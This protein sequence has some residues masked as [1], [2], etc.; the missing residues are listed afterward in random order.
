MESVQVDIFGHTY[1]IKVANDPEYIRKLAAYVD[2][3]MKEVQ[4]ST[5]TSDVYRI[6]I[7]AALNIT[8][9]LHRLRAQ[10]DDL[11][12]TTTSSLDHL[13]EITDGIK[14]K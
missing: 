5:G 1:S 7:L 11:K 14:R 3:R 6:A 13:I 9:E 8:D 2:A 10:H 4:K 12:H